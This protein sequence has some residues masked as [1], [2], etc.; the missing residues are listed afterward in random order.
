MSLFGGPDYSH[1][2]WRPQQFP[3]G[4]SGIGGLMSGLGAGMS[5]ATQHKENKGEWEQAAEEARKAGKPI[6]PKP[7]GF[8]AFFGASPQ[9]G[10][11]AGK[12]QAGAWQSSSDALRPPGAEQSPSPAP[13]QAQAQA[14]TTAA[15]PVPQAGSMLQQ[16]FT[17]LHE[18]IKGLFDVFQPSGVARSGWDN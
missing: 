11:F 14:P 10:K 5:T 16:K 3:Q 15:P 8:G 12:D 7:T 9:Y 17:A 6:P 4:E 18:A 2:I 13:V 1:I